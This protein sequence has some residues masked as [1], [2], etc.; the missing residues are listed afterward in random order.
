MSE[1]TSLRILH[2]SDW[3]LGQKLHDRERNDEFD[4]FLQ[5]MI[6][7]IN[8]EKIDVLLIAGDIFDTSTPTHAA[9][10]KYYNFC[11]KLAQTCCRHAVI[12]SGNHDSTSFIDV[13]SMLLQEMNIHAIGQAR[14]GIGKSGTPSDEV[15]VLKDLQ[16]NDELIVAAVPFLNES[17]VRYSEAGEETADKEKKVIAGIAHHYEQTALEAERIRAGRNIPVVA[18][19]HLYAQ[20]GKLTENET[21]S[22]EETSVRQ[23]YVGTL[24]GINASV[25]SSAFDYVAL[26]HLHIPQIVGNYEHIRYSGSPIAMGFGE[27]GQQ[28]S[29][30]II[31][32]NGK[33]RKI[34]LIDIPCFHKMVRIIGDKSQI[35]DQLHKLIEENEDVYVSVTYTGCEE[36]ADLYDFIDDIIKDTAFIH[37]LHTQD[38]STQKRAINELN[39]ISNITLEDLDEMGMFERLL[40]IGHPNMTMEDREILIHSFNELLIEVKKNQ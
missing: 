24:G 33:E 8:N 25:F 27:A 38:K 35:E 32:F 3:H 16:G 2:T 14:F 11:T 6:D 31:D 26:G 17:D 10:Q 19:G 21:D 28:K 4:A 15:L 5:W 12:I 7:M 29:A 1:T 9:Q 18:L 34:S 23:T 40:D 30:C 36:I 37:C 13:P 20:G 39:H 22:G